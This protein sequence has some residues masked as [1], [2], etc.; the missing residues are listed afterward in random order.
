MEANCKLNQV[1]NVKNILIDMLQFDKFENTYEVVLSTDLFDAGFTAVN[2]IN[3]WRKL[4]KV[5]G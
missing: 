2:I 4:L 1:D 5:G 3:I